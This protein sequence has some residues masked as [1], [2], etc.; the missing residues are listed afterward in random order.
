M[1]SMKSRELSNKKSSKDGLERY[2]EI[3]GT[4][5]K[6]VNI[7]TIVTGINNNGS[8]R[9]EKNEAYAYEVVEQNKRFT[10]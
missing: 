2:V 8:I 7:P 1:G 5:I 6:L 4:D 3:E 10:D 9:Q